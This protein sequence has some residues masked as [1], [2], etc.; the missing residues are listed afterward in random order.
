MT[1]SIDSFLIIGLY[2]PPRSN[3]TV[4]SV[5]I[6]LIEDLRSNYSESDFIICGDLNISKFTWHNDNLGASCTTV[7]V[8]FPFIIDIVLRVLRFF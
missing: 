2:I 7:D 5:L 1:N 8:G 6:K 4:D 3:A